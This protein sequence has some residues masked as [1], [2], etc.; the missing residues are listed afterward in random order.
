MKNNDGWTKQLWQENSLRVDKTEKACKIAY[1]ENCASSS[2]IME[3]FGFHL[4][5]YLRN[6]EIVQKEKMF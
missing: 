2:Y 6:P 5:Y 4:V 3:T 1:Y